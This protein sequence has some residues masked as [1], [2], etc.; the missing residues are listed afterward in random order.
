ML[1]PADVQSVDEN[2]DFAVPHFGHNMRR[3]PT[4]VGH[5]DLE[6]KKLFVIIIG[7]PKL[8]EDLGI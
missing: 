5:M 8:M 1:P 2:G 4:A 3:R 6:W 7:V